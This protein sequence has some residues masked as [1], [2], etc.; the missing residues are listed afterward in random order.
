[1]G[2]TI[3][4]KKKCAEKKREKVIETT[5]DGCHCRPTTM[6]NISKRGVF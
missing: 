5:G 1:M 3:W 6:A 4:K 2:T